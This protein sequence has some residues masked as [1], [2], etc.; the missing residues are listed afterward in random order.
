MAALLLGARAAWHRP[1]G[2]A[3]RLCTMV[4][5]MVSSAALDF[6]ARALHALS[7]APRRPAV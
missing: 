3:G 1:R 4:P 7:P 6:R 5:I 2:W